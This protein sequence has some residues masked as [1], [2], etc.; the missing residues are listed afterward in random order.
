MK[1]IKKISLL[2]A[3]GLSCTMNTSCTDMDL[4]PQSAVTPELYFTNA[5]QLKAY[6][7]PFY[8]WFPTH[9]TMYYGQ[10]GADYVNT[11]NQIHYDL[12]NPDMVAGETFVQA[13][14]SNN[15]KENA[16]EFSQIYSV[17]Y[18]LD[19]IEKKIESGQLAV[20]DDV[21]RA[22][23][24]AHFFRAYAYY[25]RVVEV[26][27]FPLVK[28]PLSTDDKELIEASVRQPRNE[29]M[30]FVLSEL[31]LAIEKLAKGKAADGGRKNY[32]SVDVA[33]LLKARV[34]LFEGS[35][36][37]YF[38]GTPF[39]P[40]GPGWPG[41][42][43]NP[44]Y[45]YPSGSLEDEAR[46]FLTEAM[47]A[48]KVVGDKHYAS[49]T[50]NN[51]ITPQTYTVEN[52]YCS[53]FGATDMS[54]YDE[55]LLWR[56]Y[57]KVVGTSI[58]RI[59]GDASGTNNGVGASRGLIM[60][61]LDKTGLPYY[62]EGAQFTLEDEYSLQKVR[63]GHTGWAKWQKDPLNDGRLNFHGLKYAPSTYA[64]LGRDSRI[65][66]FLKVPNLENFWINSDT[67]SQQPRYAYPAPNIV[68]AKAPSTTGY[69]VRKGLNPDLAIHETGGGIGCII[70]RAS[71]ALI[72][73]VEASYMLNKSIDGT[74]DMYWKTLRKR[75]N[76]EPDWRVTVNATDLSKEAGSEFYDWG[77]YSGGK[78]LDDKILFS[79][80]RE[81][82]HEL[83]FEGMRY[84]DLKRW[85]SLDQ[86]KEK[87]Y[88]IGGIWLWP[89]PSK[90]GSDANYNMFNDANEDVE[91][92]KTYLNSKEGVLISSRK[93]GNVIY[94]YIFNAKNPVTKAKGYT[95]FMA[96]YLAPIPIFNFTITSPNGDPS[97][98]KLYQNPYW[99][100]S[101]GGL[102]IE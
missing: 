50:V 58:N 52:P 18:L 63:L 5:A 87:P 80:R 42:A 101:A 75:A 88:L 34:A 29:V 37:T 17:N 56:E 67:K 68:S 69:Q 11:D 43:S 53:M 46:Y 99:P 13:S 74:A 47:K 35:W 4:E 98:S 54:K 97:G 89:D 94:P 2:F 70:F 62:A 78:V 8:L 26:G 96:H 19:Q 41:L 83:A 9:S 24:E 92:Q 55:V 28:K 16:Y 81:R 93:Q 27:D 36:L 61:Y 40:N 3:V 65:D 84:N 45:K 90:P 10:Y 12:Y 1:T 38:A 44:N 100:L 14:N 73:Y 95:W 20:T 86:L 57:S 76:I 66:V 60:S 6:I 91:Y 31:D 59:V 21:T 7:N 23:G 71:E 64:D 33:Q 82:R 15:S 51:G 22:I 25:R 72:T 79:I 49:L 32:L 102:A 39:V 48:A 77:L 85:R 30:R